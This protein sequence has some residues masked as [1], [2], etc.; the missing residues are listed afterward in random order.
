MNKKLQILFS[1]DI[2]QSALCWTFGTIC[3]VSLKSLF[4]LYLQT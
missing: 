1:T 3:S 2:Q 4:C